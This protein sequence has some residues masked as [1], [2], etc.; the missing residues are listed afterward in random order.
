ALLLGLDSVLIAS[1]GAGK[2]LPFAL[3]LLA[4]NT[5]LS[6]IIIVSTLNELERDQAE[7]FNNMG[8]AA[9]AVNGET[10]DD[11]LHKHERFSKLIRSPGWMKCILCTIIDEAHCITHW[12]ANF[13]KDFDK[14]GAMRSFMSISK[15]FLIASA[16]LTP[17][18]L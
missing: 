18:L 8:I 7:R 6:K 16:T 11:A 17:S 13:R 10:Y 15:P 12:G 4:D 9:A 5:G 3:P 2:T 14:L 1:T